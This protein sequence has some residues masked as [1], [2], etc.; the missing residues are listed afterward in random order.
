MRAACQI[1]FLSALSLATG[2]GPSNAGEPE[3]WR[4]GTGGNPADIEREVLWLDAPDFDEQVA[5]SEVMSEYDFWTEAASAFLLEADAA[6]RK[7]TW[8]GTYWNSFEGIPTGSGFNIRF[9]LTAT[10]HYPED[11]PFLEYLLPG[12]D[13]CEALADGGDDFSEFVYE[14]CL[15]VPLAPGTYWF[16]AQMAD[17]EFPPQWGRQAAGW[18]GQHWDSVFRSPYFSYP[19]WVRG[20]NVFMPWWASQMLEDVC[21]ATAVENT[22]WGAVKELYR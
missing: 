8:W 6:V 20:D 16:S 18:P 15:H 19:D 10:A 3:L 21:Q 5:S 9:Y 1:F 17:H 22:S 12:D 4:P 2:T 11:V 7:V 13:C 14:Y